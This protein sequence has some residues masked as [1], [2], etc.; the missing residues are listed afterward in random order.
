MVKENPKKHFLKFR[1]RLSDLLLT[2]DN[3]I[4]LQIISRY[5]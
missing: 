2:K 1:L 4:L 3:F 5:K